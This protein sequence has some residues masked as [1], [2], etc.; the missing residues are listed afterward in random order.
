MLV[1]GGTPDSTLQ[2]PPGACV[3]CNACSTNLQ[4]HNS[5]PQAAS[6][7]NVGQCV[8]TPSFFSR[9]LDTIYVACACCCSDLYAD[10][11]ADGS[12]PEFRRQL[13]AAREAEKHAKMKAALAEKQAKEAAEQQRRQEQQAHKQAHKDRI[14]TW[15]NKNKVWPKQFLSVVG[16]SFYLTVVMLVSSLCIA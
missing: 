16:V 8:V 5:Y 1:S 3:S 9:L 12:E 14:E 6:G 11:V 4:V 13:R 15:K 7:A 2:K 10:A